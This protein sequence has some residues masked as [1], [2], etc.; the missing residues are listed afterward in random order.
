MA[1]AASLNL[2]S[3]AQ[4][5]GVP[6]IPNLFFAVHSN[7]LSVVNSLLSAGLDVN[8]TNEYG[9][10]AILIAASKGF[11]DIFNALLAAG[12][13]IN[14]QGKGVKATVSYDCQHLFIRCTAKNNAKFK[15]L[16]CTFATKAGQA[17]RTV[18]PRTEFHKI[19]DFYATVN[20]HTYTYY[21]SEGEPDDWYRLTTTSLPPHCEESLPTQSMKAI[22]SSGDACTVD[23]RIQSLDTEDLEG[24]EVS[25][26]VMG[27]TAFN[28]NDQSAI[29]EEKITTYT[30]ELGRWALSLTKNQLVLLEIPSIGYNEVVRIPDQAYVLFTDLQPVNDHYYSPDGES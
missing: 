3:G 23:G 29:S 21:D 14:K 13:D 4:N 6:T 11:F 24:R 10:T 17:P 20:T 7:D 9:S 25:A 18:M 27:N 5:S 2:T 30:D 22:A 16:K 8:A 15:L 28:P 12:A 26:E 1:V 19:R